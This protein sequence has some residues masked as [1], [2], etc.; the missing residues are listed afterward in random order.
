MSYC[1]FSVGEVCRNNLM[2]VCVCVCSECG[3]KLF[4]SISKFEH[5]S[6]ETI[7]EDSVSRHPEICCGKCGNGDEGQSRFLVFSSSLWFLPKRD[8]SLFI[9]TRH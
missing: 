3:L 7:Y 6:P 5:S 9:Q 2:C 1:S 4:S 8:F